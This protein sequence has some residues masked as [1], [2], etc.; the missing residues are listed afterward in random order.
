[1][2][3]KLSTIGKIG[4]AFCSIIAFILLL[5]TS[6]C[7]MDNFISISFSG[8]S[9]LFGE[10]DILEPI[11]TALTAWILL[12]AVIVALA[13]YLAAEFFEIDFITDLDLFVSTAISVLL[14]SIGILILCVPSGVSAYFSQPFILDSGWIVAVV[15]I[16]LSSIINIAP[17]ILDLLGI[18]F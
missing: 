8:T 17:T 7:H 9:V 6:C 4:A 12:I 11:A 1:M 13:I 15:L 5:T 16:F 3:F 14:I 2:V 10:P 18:K